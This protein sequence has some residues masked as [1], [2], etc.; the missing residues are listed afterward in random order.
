MIQEVEGRVQDCGEY[1]IV[2]ADS[3]LLLGGVVMSIIGVAVVT[4]PHSFQPVDVVGYY[5]LLGKRA[6]TDVKI[7]FLIQTTFTF[8]L[9][10][11]FFSFIIFANSATVSGA[12]VRERAFRSKICDCLICIAFYKYFRNGDALGCLPCCICFIYLSD[13]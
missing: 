3:A 4:N 7:S 6:V 12:C 9:E 1:I 11:L 10:L 8:K 13:S 2:F 5:S